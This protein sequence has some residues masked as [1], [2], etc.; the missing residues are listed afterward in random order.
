MWKNFISTILGKERKFIKE[1][2]NIW[3]H[4]VHRDLN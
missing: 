2:G 4:E 3:L 1:K